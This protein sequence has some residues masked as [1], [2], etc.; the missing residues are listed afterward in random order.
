M[1]RPP[2]N[3]FPK[4]GSDQPE[5]DF[6]LAAS[7]DVRPQQLTTELTEIQNWEDFVRL[8]ERHGVSVLIYQRFLQLQ[9][10]VP[11]AVLDHLQ[12]SYELNVRKSLFLAREL[13]RVL[14]CLE[15]Q[16]IPVTPYKGIVMSEIY[17]G[18]LALRQS[19]DLDLLIRARDAGRAKKVMRELGFVPRIA[20]PE[21]AEAHYLAAGYECTF[22]SPAG[23]NLL[24]LQWA[25]HPRFYAVDFDMEG[26]FERA[27][28]VEVA[29]RR[30]RTPSAEDLLLVLSLHAAKHVWGRL[31]WLCDIA[32]IVKRELDWEWI[33]AHT[34]ELR[35]ERILT[36]TFFLLNRMLGVAVPMEMQDLVKGD[37][38]AEQLAGSIAESIA[39]GVDYEAHKIS[40]FRLIMRLRERRM[41]R[42]RFLS[43]LA[44]TPG[45]GEW[46]AV[47]LPRVLFPVYRVVRMARLAGRAVRG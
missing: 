39:T 47:R 38:A 42:M 22:D 24:E 8:A 21:A 28:E 10:D 5:W 13:I 26:L 40:Y 37:R 35:I 25:L 16:G 27:V 11:H 31:I 34:H 7:S 14:D 15:G 41:D 33:R 2:V 29:G 45:P 1:A 9:T 20:I 30:M 46:E 23:K 36:V 12:Q 18:D 4:R 43:R 3:R 32:Q 6:L 19:G 17:Y 44:L